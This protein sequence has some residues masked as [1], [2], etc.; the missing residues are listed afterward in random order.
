MTKA[1]FASAGTKKAP[2]ALAYKMVKKHVIMI[3]EC[4]VK[5]IVYLSL[6]IDNSLLC[7]SVFSSVLLSFG[8]PFSLS[9]LS[10]SR[11]SFSSLLF[12]LSKLLVSGLL[13]LNVFGNESGIVTSKKSFHFHCLIHF[14]L[15]KKFY[16]VISFNKFADVLSLCIFS[17]FFLYLILPNY[18]QSF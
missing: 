14:A 7:S 10:E 9:L 4:E 6:F 15:K 12:S 18:A 2:A 16:L 8:D 3:Q 5:S 1:T 11:V 13:L 17:T